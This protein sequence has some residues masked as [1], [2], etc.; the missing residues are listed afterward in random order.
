V[1]CAAVASNLLGLP[2]EQINNALGIAEYHA[3]NLPMMRDIDHPAMVKHGSGWGAMTGITAAELS[4]RGSTGIPGILTFEKYRDWVVDIGQNY[5]MVDGVIWKEYACC[6]WAH[7]ALGAAG[8]LARKYSIKVEDIARIKVEGFH[9]S[10]RLGAKLPDTAEEAQFNLAWPLAALLVYGEVGPEQM[11]ERSFNNPKIQ[12]VVSKI[13]LVESEELN[14]LYRLAAQGDPKGK[15]ASVV[16]V[17][18]KDSRQ[19]SSGMVES[20]IRYPQ[21]GWDEQRVEEKFRWL[22]RYALDEPR[23]DELV[24][25]VWHFEEISDVRELTQIVAQL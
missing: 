18:L 25:M 21:P 12:D 22:M 15:Y 24:N 4:S 10:L 7:A 19:F 14:R 11:L 16:T 23:T 2:L 6:A 13:E 20:K 9:E 1:A 8:M 17:T 5:I 3:P